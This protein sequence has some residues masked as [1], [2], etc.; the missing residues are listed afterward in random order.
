MA[1]K[2]LRMEVAETDD[3]MIRDFNREVEFLKGIRHRNIVLFFGAGRLEQAR[4]PFL[5]LEY[6]ERGSLDKLLHGPDELAWDVRVGIASDV[7]RGM[8]FLHQRDPPVLH[9]DLKSLNVLLNNR[10]IAKVSKNINCLC[11]KGNY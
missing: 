5:V 6:M 3:E 2:K 10:W 1:V 11:I 4:C 7:A 8:Q 9:R